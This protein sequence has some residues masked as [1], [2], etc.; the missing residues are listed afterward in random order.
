MSFDLYFYKSNQSRI[1]E[2]DVANYLTNNIPFIKSENHQWF[3]DNEATGVYFSFDNNEPNSEPEDIEFYDKFNGFTN[4][5]FLFNINFG[6]PQFFGLEAFPIID[7][8]V[9]D[10]D[11]FVF[12]PQE[13]AFP[14]KFPIGNLQDLWMRLNTMA[15]KKLLEELKLDYLELEKSNYLWS[16]QFKRGSLQNSI[17]EDIFVPGYFVIKNKD[18]GQL[19][20]ACV[21]PKH[22]P[23]ILP[24]VDYIIIDKKIKKIFKTVE[25][26]GVIGYETVMSQLGSYFENF[27]DE[28]PNL[29]KLSQENSDKLERQYNS[30][31]IYKTLEQFGSGVSFSSFV[32]IKKYTNS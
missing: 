6:R 28:L 3:Y 15:A 8:F 2:E 23:I 30:L 9:S 11:L 17:T 10:L 18:D 21:W 1:T 32:N 26:F 29:K 16:F 31:P 12:D 20:T 19:Y 13:G 4:L 25:F 7:K 27:E 24:P 22:L 5:N 14:T